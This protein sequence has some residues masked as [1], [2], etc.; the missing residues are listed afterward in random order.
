M[1]GWGNSEYEQLG[2]V[3][4]NTQVNVPQHLPISHCG[5][6]VK[7][8]AGGSTC[9]L[10]NGRTALYCFVVV[11]LSFFVC[12]VSFFFFSFKKNYLLVNL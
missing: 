10:L 3:T 12:L 1:F 11:F 4:D 6:V 7:A 2:A 9:A 5:K 8:V